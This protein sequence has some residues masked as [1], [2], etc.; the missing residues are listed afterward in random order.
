ET[1]MVDLFLKEA[2]MMR[3]FRHRHVLSL[4]GIAFD[5]DGSPMVVLPFME[6]GDLRRYI[7]NPS[8]DITVLE[9]LKLGLQVTR[10][11]VYLSS[12]RFVHRDLAAR[13]CM[14]DLEG[15]VKVADFGLSRE[16]FKRDYYR[17]E[18]GK[19]PLPIR[20][21]A[22]ECLDRNVFTTM[23]DVWSLG[24]L[25]WELMT[26]GAVP[27][28]EVDNWDIPTYIQT[29]R[30]LPQPAYCPYSVYEIMQHTWADDP[31]RRPTF[32]E[33]VGRLETIIR[34]AHRPGSPGTGTGTATLAHL[35]TNVAA[36][37]APLADYRQTVV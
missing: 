18:D 26:R 11:M 34:A 33:L 19:T 30:R 14:V 15:V 3:D 12:M 24:V 32:Q 2:L 9:L 29:N 4:I 23:S 31:S 10:G 27:Y 7:L 16:L 35:Y 37:V 8:M 6:Q 28:P 22:P 36:P 21:M 20:W 25:L 1:E 13:N 5:L 17:L